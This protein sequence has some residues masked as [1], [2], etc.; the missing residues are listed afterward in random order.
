PSPGGTYIVQDRYLDPAVIAKE[1]KFNLTGP[2]NNEPIW[3]FSSVERAVMAR[4]MS[5]PIT[6]SGLT[7]FVL[8]APVV[9]AALFLILICCR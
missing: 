2:M 6:S 1:N 3:R 4:A 8:I 9:G 7:F 5:R